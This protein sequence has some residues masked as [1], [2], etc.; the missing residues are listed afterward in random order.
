MA[1]SSTSLRRYD[2]TRPS[3]STRQAR[4]VRATALAVAGAAAGA[5]AIAGSEL[6]AGLV[7]GAPSLV[8]AV[9]TLVIS[10]QP[11]GAKEVFVDLFGTNDKP[12]LNVLVVGAAIAIAAVAGL[13]AGRRLRYGAAVFVAF[14]IVAFAAALAAP[15]VEPVLAAA[16]ATLAVTLGVLALAVLV[17]LAPVAPRAAPE[18]TSPPAEMPEWDRRRF[19]IAS[20]GTLGGAVAV[21][22]VGRI[23]RR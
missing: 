20:A 3:L 4:L 8:I 21:G 13:L 1:R 12:A 11:P 6:F 7:A 15:L 10:L 23:A 14:G 22:A 18:T 17:P 9:G 2:P 16:N 5:L 19:L